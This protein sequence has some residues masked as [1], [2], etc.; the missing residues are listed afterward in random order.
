M[1]RVKDTKELAY[2]TRLVSADAKWKRILDVQYPYRANLSNLNIQN[3]LDVGCGIGRN[4]QNL[5]R[6]GVSAVGVDHNE[7]SVAEA[8]RRG[9]RALTFPEF[10]KKY[11]PEEPVFESILLSHVV[12]HMREQD[13]VTVL[14]DYLDYLKPGGKVIIITPQEA[15]YK[16]DPTHVNFVD[17]NISQRILEQAGLTYDRGYNFPFPR[18]VGKWFPYN[19]FVAVS[20]K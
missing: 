8:T 3:V 16:T 18:W 7:H 19:E 17:L 2:K 10:Q 15:G 9:F 20:H 1:N 6:L 11:S 12:E 4:L 5:D 13:A 14:T